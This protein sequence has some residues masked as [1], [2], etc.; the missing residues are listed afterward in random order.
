MGAYLNGVLIREFM[1]SDIL[2]CALSVVTNS[3]MYDF[4]SKINI[5]LKF[6]FAAWYVFSI[7]VTDLR[8]LKTIL[9]EIR[10]TGKHFWINVGDNDHG[11]KAQNVRQ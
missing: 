10:P 8:D 4:L 9:L 3:Q 7:A 1:V 6:F 11:V 2:L 5:C